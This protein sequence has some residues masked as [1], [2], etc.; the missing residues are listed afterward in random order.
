MPRNASMDDKGLHYFLLLKGHHNFNDLKGTIEWFVKNLE[1]FK[2][3][4]VVPMECRISMPLAHHRYN[5]QRTAISSAAFKAARGNS[6]IL[7]ERHDKRLD[8]RLDMITSRL[9]WAILAFK[10][11]HSGIPMATEL[12]FY[13]H[14]NGYFAKIFPMIHT[15]T[16]AVG[17]SAAI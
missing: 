5:E 1:K 8:N 6:K 10:K 16:L 17:I 7:E 9:E 4:G 2:S 15:G 12:C 14:S 3:L 11:N 13:C